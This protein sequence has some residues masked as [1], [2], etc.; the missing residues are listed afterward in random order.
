MKKNMVSFYL[1][2]ALIIFLTTISFADSWL[3]YRSKEYGFEMLIPSRAKFIEKEWANG[4]GG[5]YSK[6]EGIEFYG[7][8]KTTEET[9][10]DIE[11]YGVQLTKIAEEH[12]TKIDE[13]K[14]SNGWKWF[15]LYKAQQGNKVIY[16]GLGTGPKGS[17]LLLLKTTTEDEKTN[18]KDYNKWYHSLKVFE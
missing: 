2:I 5:L 12:W 14:N 18:V 16:A 4:W 7:L 13:G 10:D 11:Q 17:Y 8:V 15:K 9:A 1:S 6:Y 3:K